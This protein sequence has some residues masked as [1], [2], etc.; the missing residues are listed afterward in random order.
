VNRP[1]LIL[2]DEPT[3]NLDSAT[4]GEIMGL[5]QTL[6]RDQG[7]TIVLVTHE[8]DIAEYAKRQIHFKDGLVV[9]DHLTGSVRASMEH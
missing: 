9:S 4:S 1:S 3:G 6:N 8:T 2:A 5:F 7:I